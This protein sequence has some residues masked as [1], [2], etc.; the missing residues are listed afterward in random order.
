MRT[1]KKSDAAA[2][3]PPAGPVADAKVAPGFVQLLRALGDETRLRIVTLLASASDALCVCE[4]EARFDLTQPTIS[5]HLKVLRDAGIV[6]AAKRGTW[7]YY[8]VDVDRVDDLV[9]LHQ[10]LRR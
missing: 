5:H 3:C 9:R 6:S 4:I 2:C 10:I 8:A 1:S 7:V